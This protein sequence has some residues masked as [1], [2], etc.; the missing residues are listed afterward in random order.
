M[1][2]ITPAKVKDPSCCS[3]KEPGGIVMEK[4]PTWSVTGSRWGWS[5]GAV[6]LKVKEE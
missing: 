5:P 2:L 6:L 1:P 3:L 4:V